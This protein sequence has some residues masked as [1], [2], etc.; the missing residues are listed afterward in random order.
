MQQHRRCCSLT[1]QTHSR[2]H[3]HIHLL[4]FTSPASTF[5][6]PSLCSVLSRSRWIDRANTTSVAVVRYELRDIHENVVLIEFMAMFH[7]LLSSSSCTRDNCYER[8]RQLHSFAI[9]ACF[10]ESIIPGAHPTSTFIYATLLH[11]EFFFI[12]Y[13]ILRRSLFVRL[14]V[15]LTS[16]AAVDAF[17]QAMSLRHSPFH[18]Y[19]PHGI[20]GTYAMLVDYVAYIIRCV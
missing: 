8:T 19:L 10:T 17:S 16:A 6:P 20:C 1:S 7:V 4:C 15:C 11:L 9:S 14:S 12:F 2:S 3:S 5:L 18:V 13:N